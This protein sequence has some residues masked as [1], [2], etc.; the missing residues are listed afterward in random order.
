MSSTSVG[1]Y[2]LL[3]TGPRTGEKS[4]TFDVDLSCHLAVALPYLVLLGVK[5]PEKAQE[6]REKDGLVGFRIQW[7][8]PWEFDSPHSHHVSS[9]FVGRRWLAAAYRNAI[10]AAILL[11]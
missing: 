9:G 3:K 7:G 11:R 8:N 5:S 1:S 6:C 4:L 2:S 10:V